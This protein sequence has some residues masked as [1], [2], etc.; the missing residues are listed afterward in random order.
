MTTGETNLSVI[1]RNMKPVVVPGEYVFC[2]VRDPAQLP[3]HVIRLLFQEQEGYTLV[4]PKEVAEHYNLP[5]IF[6]SAWITLQ[7]HSSLAAT[8]L[9]AAFSAALAQEGI[10]CNVVAAYF[11]DHLFVPIDLVD[12]ALDALARLSRQ[13]A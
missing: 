10:S 1:L 2:T 9:T 13:H 3:L 11:H 5:G 7:I 4:V 6:P 8:G 12:R